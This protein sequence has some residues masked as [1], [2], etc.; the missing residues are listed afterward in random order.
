MNGVSNRPVN[1]F[2]QPRFR[3]RGRDEGRER[4]RERATV[5][6]YE[7]VPLDL[8]YCDVLFEEQNGFYIKLCKQQ[9]RCFNETCSGKSSFPKPKSVTISPGLP[10]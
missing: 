3:G 2:H 8:C 4:E 9:K 6:L 1:Y 10:Y 7:V 5:N